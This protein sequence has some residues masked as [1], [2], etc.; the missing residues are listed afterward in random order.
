MEE[1]NAEKNLANA[2]P[3]TSTVEGWIDQAKQT[4]P[5]ICY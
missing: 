5:K 1:I 2:T 3:S 4:D